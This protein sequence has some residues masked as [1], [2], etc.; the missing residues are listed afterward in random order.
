MINTTE[1]SRILLL[2]LG[3]DTDK[4]EIKKIGVAELKEIFND[5][6]HLTK[7]I[8]FTRKVLLKAFLEYDS[9]DSA[10]KA[11]KA[12]HEK[13]VKTYGKARAYFSPLQDL[14][15][16][17]KYLE[18]WE[19][20]SMDK[21]FKTDD[22]V[23]TK[24]S[25]R[26]SD[27]ENLNKKQGCQKNSLRPNLSKLNMGAE[28]KLFSTS[29]DRP[30]MP[31]HQS[32][33]L[34]SNNLVFSSQTNF[35]SKMTQPSLITPIEI[36]T[37]P[38]NVDF[39]TERLLVISK[40]VLVSNLAN[41]FRNCEEMFNLFSAF[42]NIVKI[43]LMKNLQKALIEYTDVQYANEAVTNL[44]SLQLGETK[45]HVSFS[46]YKTVDLKKNNKNENSMQFNEVLLVPFIKNR[47]KSNS[48]IPICSISSSL[49]VSFP[50]IGKIQT[51]DV[52]LTI[53][54]FC[55]PVKT[56]L[57]SNKSI[58]GDTEVVNMLF[59]FEDIQSAVYVMYKCHNSVV[60]GALLDVFFF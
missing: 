3:L 53:E 19:E 22:D 18:F 49:L 39:G 24:N 44:N 38:S 15:F 16:S 13:I 31:E 21:G 28:Y 42:G 12:V 10:D 25:L 54:R 17:N 60:K 11:K 9:F 29:T 35:F 41:V 45:L 40:V 46:K 26:F 14:K 37:K 48:Q 2:N 36:N 8:V 33:F 34:S 50:K 7:V 56:K 30:V 59:S 57:V 47:F 55:K 5:F 52:Y 27:A 4:I 6:G 58:N 43:L 23:S 32:N 1:K 20:S 51:I